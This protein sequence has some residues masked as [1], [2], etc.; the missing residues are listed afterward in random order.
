MEKYP[1]V[2]GEKL[3]YEVLE[4]GVHEYETIFRYLFNAMP[5]LFSKP[6]IQ[7]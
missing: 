3:N 7:A 1:A 4:D 2:F 5:V 6:E